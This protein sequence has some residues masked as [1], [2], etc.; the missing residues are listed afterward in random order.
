MKNEYLLDFRTRKAVSRL[1]VTVTSHFLFGWD[2]ARWCD[3]NQMLTCKQHRTVW[4]RI[5]PLVALVSDRYPAHSAIVRLSAQAFCCQLAGKYPAESTQSANTQYKNVGEGRGAWWRQ[6]KHNNK[7]LQFYQTT[8][9]SP[10]S[11]I[12]HQNEETEE[13]KQKWHACKVFTFRGMIIETGSHKSLAAWI[14]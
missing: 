3:S 5:L 9:F 6:V 10:S 1:P 14:L 11:I 4:W 2:G 7:S 13:K 8:T 12:S